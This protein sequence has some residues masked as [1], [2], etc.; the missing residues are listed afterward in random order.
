VVLRGKAFCERPSALHRQ[1]PE[2]DKQ[3]VDVSPLQNFLHTPML[4]QSCRHG[5]ALVGLAPS[6]KAPSSPKLKREAL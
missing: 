6:N 2:H 3:N 5:G 4:T 1:Q